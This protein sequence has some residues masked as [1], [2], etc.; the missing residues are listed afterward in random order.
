MRPTGCFAP[1]GPTSV[2]TAW[3]VFDDDGALLDYDRQEAASREA[4]RYRILVADAYKFTRKPNV[5][6]GQLDEQDLVITDAPLPAPL[7]DRVQ[8]V[9]EIQVV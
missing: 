8:Q 6:G 1:I 5:R 2:C 9:P 4:S 7:C 3:A